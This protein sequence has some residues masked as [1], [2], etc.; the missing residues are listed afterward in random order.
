MMGG[1]PKTEYIINGKKLVWDFDEAETNPD[2]LKRDNLYLEDIWNM[3][4]T[5]GPS[6]ACADLHILSPDTFYFVTTDGIGVT[7]RYGGSRVVG[8][9]RPAFLPKFI[10]KLLRGVTT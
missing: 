3:K 5:A 6:N 4:E 2:N 9:G 8:L 1:Q 7:M 10:V